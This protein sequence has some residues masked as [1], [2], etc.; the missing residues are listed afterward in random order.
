MTFLLSLIYWEG[1]LFL[2]SAFGMIGM[3]MLEGSIRLDG[4]LYGTKGDGSKY[5]SPERV[6]LLLITLAVAFQLLS[7]VLRNPTNFPDVP[8]S[9]IAMLGGSHAVYLGGKALAVFLGNK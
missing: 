9:S 3:L 2:F 6:Q 5:F 7:A 8:A 4:L 1:L